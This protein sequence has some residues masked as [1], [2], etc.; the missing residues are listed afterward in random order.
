MV[1][2]ISIRVLFF[3]STTRFCWGVLGVKK[4]CLITNLSQNSLTLELL[5]FVLWTDLIPIIL[6]FNFFCTFL[7]KV[8]KTKNVSSFYQKNMV[9]VNMEQSS[10]TTRMYL[11]PFV[12]AILTGLNRFIWSSSRGLDMLTCFLCLKEDLVC[13]PL[14]KYHTFC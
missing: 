2:A 4:L 7:A 11:L 12:L 9:Q 5:N 6:S 13:F 8:T 14:H 10:P 3:L 1:R